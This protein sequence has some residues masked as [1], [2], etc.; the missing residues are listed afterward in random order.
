M[1]VTCEPCLS[2]GFFVVPTPSGHLRP[3]CAVPAA[4]HRPSSWL[5]ALP[6]ISI[7]QDMGG[8]SGDRTM[9]EGASNT[10]W[11]VPLKTLKLGDDPGDNPHLCFIPFYHELEC[12]FP[13]PLSIKLHSRGTVFL[14]TFLTGFCRTPK[15]CPFPVYWWLDHL[16]LL[17]PGHWG[18]QERQ[19]GTL[20][21]AEIKRRVQPGTYPRSKSLLRKSRHLG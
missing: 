8:F 5:N 7:P 18:R 10:V 9:G 11:H 14:I 4:H 6:G 3:C 1:W 12:D 16:M 17:S 13:Q 15:P 21:S 20:D 2:L 19:K